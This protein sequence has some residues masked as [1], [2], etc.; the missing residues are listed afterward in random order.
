MHNISY[1]WFYA[2]EGGGGKSVEAAGMLHC[3]GVL[4]P[5][6]CYCTTLNESLVYSVSGTVNFF[7]SPLKVIALGSFCCVLEEKLW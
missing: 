6:F 4:F 7:S 2:N 1:R 3:C 5:F